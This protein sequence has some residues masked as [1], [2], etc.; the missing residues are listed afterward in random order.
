MVR[1]LAR[2]GVSLALILGVLVCP[3]AARAWT[4]A[5]VRSV[6][7]HVT[8]ARDASAEVELVA[9][10]RVDGGW[11]QAFELDGL[12][13][14]LEL[15]PGR[16][17]FRDAEGVLLE[18]RVDVEGEGRVVFGF[19]R[20][21]AP[22]RGDYVA[23]IVYRTS[24]AHRATEVREDGTVLVRWVLPGWRYGLDDVAITL[25]APEGA[26]PVRDEDDPAVEVTHAPTAT[27]TR[28]VFHRVHLPRTRE[29]VVTLAL[30]AGRMDTSLHVPSTTPRRA[31]PAPPMDAPST[32]IGVPLLALA[33]AVIAVAKSLVVAR[34]ERAARVPSSALVPLGLGAR[35]VIVVVLASAAAMLHEHV[36]LALGLL[37]GVALCAIHRR[38]QEPRAPR[39]GSFRATTPEDHAR[40][41]R[42]LRTSRLDVLDPTTVPGAT[43]L[44]VVIAA[45]LIAWSRGVLPVPLPIAMVA[46]ALATTV[47]LGGTR[48]SRPAAAHVE[49]AHLLALAAQLRADLE[50]DRRW[51]MRPVL[52]TDVRGEAQDA[53]LR[54]VLAAMPKGLLRLDVVR[55]ARADRGGWSS[56]PVLLV[57]TREGSPADRALDERFPD[58]RIASAPRRIARQLAIEPD[59]ARTLAPVLEALAACPVETAPA[60]RSVGTLAATA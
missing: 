44:G 30:P 6:S 1:P 15:V 25:D 59:L 53:R 11:L 52:H 60:P 33:L 50:D 46:A 17:S 3:R 16:A 31:R 41:R 48:R 21:G 19:R 4:D 38:A 9:Q 18:P 13:P 23:T 56:E 54:I 39:L 10:V 26:A 45:P 37:G 40:A 24:L 57:V 2:A 22:R 29:W 51:A 8:I 35:V 7:A 55:A 14:D 12:D 34:A 27:G 28:V 43:L 20:R 49:L 32:P 36:E 42:A 58:A 5:T 47:L